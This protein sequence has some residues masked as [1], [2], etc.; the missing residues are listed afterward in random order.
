MR[1]CPSQ[2]IEIP[3]ELRT[4][5]SHYKFIDKSLSNI[6]DTLED[7]ETD[8]LMSQLT[9]IST[10]ITHDFAEISRTLEH[11]QVRYNTS[12]QF[13]ESF[14]EGLHNLQSIY[15]DYHLFVLWYAA[16]IILGILFLVKVV[17]LI[18]Y[19]INCWP[20]VTGFY[21]DFTKYRRV[22]NNEEGNRANVGVN[23]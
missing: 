20:N 13:F 16:L 17:S 12:L 23:P 4:L 19:C 22:R 21:S 5:G 3:S 6:Q 15:T 9:Q 18:M 10:F 8:Q 1:I 2:V 7:V 14:D 11:I